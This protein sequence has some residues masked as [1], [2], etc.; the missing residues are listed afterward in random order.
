MII[1]AVGSAFG[2]QYSAMVQLL[3]FLLLGLGIDDAF[4]IVQSYRQVWTWSQ[5]A[6]GSNHTCGCA[7]YLH[8]RDAVPV[9]Q[10]WPI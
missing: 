1:T 2:L 5:N 6:S 8:T 4:V 3:G 7:P 9:R 10:L